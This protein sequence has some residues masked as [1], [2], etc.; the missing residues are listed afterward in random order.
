MTL[1]L[2]V[3]GISSISLCSAQICCYGCDG[4][5][6]GAAVCTGIGCGASELAGGGNG[7]LVG[8]T[9][10]GIDGDGSRLVG[11]T[12]GHMSLQFLVYLAAELV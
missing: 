8:G 2:R 7:L 4:T 12:T 3:H 10:G 11:S 9:T 1:V 6:Y 5:V